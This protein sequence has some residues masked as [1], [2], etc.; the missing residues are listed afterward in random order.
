MILKYYSLFLF[1]IFPF[2]SFFFPF[3]LPH[4]PTLSILSVVGINDFSNTSFS[5]E[6]ICKSWVVWSQ[7]S[8]SC[9]VLLFQL[10][11]TYPSIMAWD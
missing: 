1:L 8:V 5:T 11:L 4:S 7:G 9:T 6:D 3:H 10:L 2:S